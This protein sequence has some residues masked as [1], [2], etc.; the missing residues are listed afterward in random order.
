MSLLTSLRSTARGFRRSPGFFV[1]AILTLGLGIGANS[2]IFTVVNAVLIRPL[3]YPEPERLV[4]V[5]HTAPGVGF[6]VLEHSDGTYL[7]YRRHNKVLEDLG[8]F[9]DGS[10]ALTGGREPE[11]VGAAGV[12]PSVFGILRVPPAV[13]RTL[14][15]ADGGPGG[16]P[17]LVLSHGLWQRLFSGDPQAIGK[18]LRIDG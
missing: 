14:V 3:P 1:L 8:I 10:V 9:S 17:V 12:S 5:M 13:G 2:A 6:D 16:E 4:S 11:Q 7:L 18:I 15:E